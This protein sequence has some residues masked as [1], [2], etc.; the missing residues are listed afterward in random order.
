MSASAPKLVRPRETL[1]CAHCAFRVAKFYVGADGKS[2][3]GWG[4][5]MAHVEMR[6]PDEAAT[7]RRRIDERCREEGVAP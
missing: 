7:L 2:R 3:S 5:L 1:R 4:K 6:H